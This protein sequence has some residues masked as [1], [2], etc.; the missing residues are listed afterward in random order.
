MPAITTHDLGNLGINPPPLCSIQT[1]F[2]SVIILT[3][4]N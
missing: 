4:K 1:L 2:G 3:A